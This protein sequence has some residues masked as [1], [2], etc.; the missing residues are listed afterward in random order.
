MRKRVGKSSLTDERVAKLDKLGFV[1]DRREK[2]WNDMFKDL[3]KYKE[4]N[5]TTR[6]KVTDNVVLYHWC[7]RQRQLNALV[8]D[9]NESLLQPERKMYLDEIGF[10]FYR[11]QSSQRESRI[12]WKMM[13]E[14]IAIL[15]DLGLE[16]H[17]LDQVFG[18]L[19]F[20]PDGV[21]ILE[22]DSCVIF[23]EI[24]ERSH[25][26]TGKSYTVPMEKER[27]ESLKKEANRLGMENVVFIRVNTGNLTQVSPKQLVTIGKVLKEIRF[28][29]PAGCS[30]HYVDYEED[31]VHVQAS[32]ES[33]KE[34]LGFI[35]NVKINHSEYF[36]GKATKLTAKDIR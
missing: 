23:V 28:D 3:V 29:M 24:D 18:A 8:N 16:W 1:W 20:R 4:K 5:G 2:A 19:R 30:I 33:M 11:R 9:S 22:I 32:I 14:L 15:E 17:S 21:L 34:A 7:T 27:E 10:D 12:E 26:P 25:N 13:H 35:D 6:V 36:D 31:H